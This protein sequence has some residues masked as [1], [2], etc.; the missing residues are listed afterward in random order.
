[1]VAEKNVYCIVKIRKKR[2]DSFQT[3]DSI[4]DVIQFLLTSTLVVFFNIV[5]ML[6][7]TE[8]AMVNFPIDSYYIS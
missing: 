3:D 2:L 7:T 1:M 6:F 4:P 5:T 8:S